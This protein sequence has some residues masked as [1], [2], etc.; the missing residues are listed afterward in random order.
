[1]STKT[2]LSTVMSSGKKTLK[3]GEIWFFMSSEWIRRIHAPVSVQEVAVLGM[4][5]N[6]CDKCGPYRQFQTLSLGHHGSLYKVLAYRTCRSC[7]CSYHH[8]VE[9]RFVT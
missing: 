4:Y 7:G 3:T 2:Q 5:A 1:M 9:F 8:V 6:S